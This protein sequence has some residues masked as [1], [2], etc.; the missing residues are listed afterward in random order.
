MLAGIPI[1]IKLARIKYVYTLCKKRENEGHLSALRQLAEIAALWIIRGIGYDIYHYAGMYEK[2]TSWSY[3]LGFLSYKN[4]R[5]KI[6]EINARKFHGASQFKPIEKAIFE[7]FGIP[8]AKYIGTLNGQWGQTSDGSQLRN[9]KDFEKCLGEFV[10]QKVCFK[11]LEGSNG[12]GFKVFEVLQNRDRI[13]LTQVATKKEYSADEIFHLLLN[14]CQDGWL[15]EEYIEQH[16][17]LK[18]FNPTSVNTIRMFLYKDKNGDVRPIKSFLKTGKPGALIDKTENGGAAVFIDQGTGV[19][20]RGFN[21]S[22]EMKPLPQH[23]N[24]KIA[25]EGV[26]I[27]FWK[28][29]EK[30]AVDTLKVFPGTRFVGVDIAITERGPLM[31][32]MNVHPDGDCLPVL[33][34]P[35]AWL[36]NNSLLP[37]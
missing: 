22:P 37:T 34:V 20:L 14:E 24:S 25:F 16:P 8:T 5:K 21:W 10:G 26:R 17:I 23:P 11:L 1:M 9:T 32:E 18:A 3:K 19:L 2:P 7:H 33:R 6:F 13:F 4:Y 36:F 30:V 31:V 15:L 12:R 28:E 35:T 29:A 27:P